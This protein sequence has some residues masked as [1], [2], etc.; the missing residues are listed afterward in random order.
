M[1]LTGHTLS[2]G[3]QGGASSSGVTCLAGTS[4]RDLCV[5]SELRGPFHGLSD[6]DT[7]PFAAGF[8]ELRCCC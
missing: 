2:L 3:P 8:L 6:P 4:L 5:R 1:T 7:F